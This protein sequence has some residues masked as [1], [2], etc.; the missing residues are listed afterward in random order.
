MET[1]KWYIFIGITVKQYIC[2]SVLKFFNIGSR[3]GI[4][5]IP[6]NQFQPN[7]IYVCRYLMYIYM[8]YALLDWL[9][10]LYSSV[11]FCSIFST[12]PVH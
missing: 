7:C 2:S 8:Y 6:R 12:F 4:I 9:S 10:V 3:I 11:L 1:P 5:L